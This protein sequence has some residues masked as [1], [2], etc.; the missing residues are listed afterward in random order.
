MVYINLIDF[1]AFL[2]IGIYLNHLI[3]LFYIS[4]RMDMTLW[5]MGIVKT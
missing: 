2:E 5:D 3:C 1:T 4:Q